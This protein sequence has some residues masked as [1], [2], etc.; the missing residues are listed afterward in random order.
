LKQ[1]EK[2][3]YVVR[4]KH[5]FFSVIRPLKYAITKECLHAYHYIILY[6][7]GLVSIRSPS[8]AYHANNADIARW[9]RDGFPHPYS[10]EDADRFISMATRDC[11][12]IILAIEVEG[13]AVGGIR[14]HPF[15]DIYRMTAE[16]GYW[17]SPE[18]QGR[19]IV[20]DAVR[21]ILPVGFKTLN[22]NRIQAGVFHTNKPSIRVLEKCGFRLEAVHKQAII[23]NGEYLDECLYVLINT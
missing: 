17:L 9:M 2:N 20:T 1:E 10:R 18:F 13:R 4:R 3:L 16:I 12:G 22:L 7:S 15:D 5:D 14:I 21:A 6:P 23:K 11:P 19:G 8:L